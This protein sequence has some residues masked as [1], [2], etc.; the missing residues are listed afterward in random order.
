MST[1]LRDE[2]L[3]ADLSMQN[4]ALELQE[5]GY[6]CGSLNKFYNDSYENDDDLHESLKNA[7]AR[8][9]AKEMGPTFGKI[10]H[11]EIVNDEYSR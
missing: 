10:V 8:M 1:S 7:V 2:L 9:K 11:F 4:L 3:P 5:G 6:D